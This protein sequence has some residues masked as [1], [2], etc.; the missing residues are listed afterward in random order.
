MKKMLTVE[1][2]SLLF[3][4]YD[5]YLP[6]TKSQ[7]SLGFNEDSYIKSSI[8]YETELYMR[9][10][11]SSYGL[12][13]SNMKDIFVTHNLKDAFL[14][15][16]RKVRTKVYQLY[17]TE[18]RKKAARENAEFLETIVNDNT[19]EELEKINNIYT[20]RHS[21]EFLENI[22]KAFKF[23]GDEVEISQKVKEKMD[24]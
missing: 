21:S 4:G 9:R 18:L 13:D 22:Y 3:Q 8:A 1:E 20:N 10:I 5:E 15:L 11:F 2:A 23:I 17:K 16:P 14:K 6:S 12:L 7:F 24:M 19:L